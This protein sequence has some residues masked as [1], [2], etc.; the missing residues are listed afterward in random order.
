MQK[1]GP[2]CHPPCS[3]G[4]SPPCSTVNIPRGSGAPGTPPACRPSAARRQSAARSA[5]CAACGSCA[6]P[7]ASA[8]DRLHNQAGCS[9]A[10]RSSMRQEFTALLLEF[11]AARHLPTPPTA[12]RSCW[13][14]A[15]WSRLMQSQL[16][17]EVARQ[18]S[19]CSIW[20]PNPNQSYVLNLNSIHHTG[21]QGWR[22]R[23]EVHERRLAGAIGAHNRN[24]AAHVL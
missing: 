11:G 15:A 3:Q 12:C 1:Q 17:H 4:R 10:R 22:T 5:R 8:Q 23:E 9:V 19:H 7:L 6:A 21:I 18:H 13:P 14:S 20:T 16:M 2:P 24:A